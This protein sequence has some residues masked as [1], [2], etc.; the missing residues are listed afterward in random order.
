LQ[1]LDRAIETIPGTIQLPLTRATMLCRLGLM[2]SDEFSRLSQ[3]MAQQAYSARYYE[4]FSTFN[5]AIVDDNCPDVTLDALRNMYVRMLQHPP[6][7]KAGTAGYSQLRFFE[8]F[9]DVY[10][11][12]P[13]RATVAFRD[14]LASRSGAGHAMFMAALFATK[15]YYEYALQFSELALEQLDSADGP[16]LRGTRVNRQDILDFQRE[17]HKNL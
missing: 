13:E 6:N 14:S 2:Q 12:E 9:I 16:A 5:M 1:V 17:V 11:G 4:L 8:G 10:L 7:N 15:E 3:Y